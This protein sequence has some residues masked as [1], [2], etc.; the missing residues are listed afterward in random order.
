MLF[1]IIDLSLLGIVRLLL[2]ISI[3][4]ALGVF[5]SLYIT[6]KNRI[7]YCR[8]RDG[9][10]EDQ[11]ITAETHGFLVTNRDTQFVKHG[12]AYEFMARFGRKVTTYFGKEGTAYTWMLQGFKPKVR[13][14]G[15]GE[16][17]YEP[18]RIEHRFESLEDAV[19]YA[20]GRKFYN[21]VPS[22]QREQ[23]QDKEMLVTVDLEPGLTPEGYTPL[24][25]EDINNEGDKRFYQM[26]G[27]AIRAGM[28][29]PS[30]QWIFAVGTG[31]GI[32][33][34]IALFFGFIP[35]GGGI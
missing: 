34:I 19:V 1:G 13:S 24:T 27:E 18:I 6:P 28:K 23:L 5:M 12:R 4:T 21:T 10:A 16:V 20:W 17:T 31:I 26:L 32:A 9:R 29:T 25:E 8:E 30:L 15:N 3:G 33:L 2:G 7:L 22:R 11:K 14:L 35:T